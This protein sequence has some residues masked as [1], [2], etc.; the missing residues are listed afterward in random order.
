MSP[1]PWRPPDGPPERPAGIPD[2]GPNA[3]VLERRSPTRREVWA[4]VE[5]TWVA[6]TVQAE[7]RDENG[8]WCFA[9][10][11]GHAD[12]VHEARTAP[13]APSPDDVAWANRI[14]H[15]NDPIPGE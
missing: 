14:W 10:W 13:W 1:V 2:H 6:A 3:P 4:W 5:G 9:R 15:R 11:P 7:T 8:W 12:W